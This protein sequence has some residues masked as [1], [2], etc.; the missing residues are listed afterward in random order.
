MKWTISERCIRQARQLVDE[1]RVIDVTPDTMHHRWLADVIADR[2]YHVIL[3]GTAQEKDICQCDYWKQHGYCEH[4]VAVE[5]QLNDKKIDRLMRENVNYAELFPQPRPSHTLVNRLQEFQK[6]QGIPTHTVEPL[7]LSAVVWMD[8]YH[9]CF[10]LELKIALNQK[11]ERLYVVRNVYDFLQAYSNCAVFEVNTRHHFQLNENVFKTDERQ[12]LSYLLKL[13]KEYCYL[14]GKEAARHRFERTVSLSCDELKGLMQSGLSNV[15]ENGILFEDKTVSLSFCEDKKPFH[16][17]LNGK[18][19]SLIIDWQDSQFWEKNHSIYLNEVMYEMNEQQW[20]LISLLHNMFPKEKTILEYEVSEWDDLCRD[21]LPL[22]E[23]I[24]HIQ[25]D[26]SLQKRL[27][28]KSLETHFY[29][30]TIPGQLLL[31]VDFQYGDVIFSS[32]PRKSTP[33]NNKLVRRDMMREQQILEILQQFGYRSVERN[34]L[35]K[36]PKSEALYRFFTEEI[37]QLKQYGTVQMDASL[38]NQFIND[39]APLIHVDESSEWLNIRFDISNIDPSEVEHILKTLKHHQSFYELKSGQMVDLEGEAFRQTSQVLEKLRLDMTHDGSIQLP[40]YQALQL[41]DTLASLDSVVYDDY[42]TTLADYLRHPSHFKVDVPS[43]LNASLRDYQFEGFQWMKMLSHYQLAGILADDMGLGKTL[44]TIT[45][46]L[47]EKE[48]GCLEHPALIVAPASLTYNWQSEIVRFAP[49]MSVQVVNGS[50]ENRIHLIEHSSKYDA[51]ITSYASFRQDAEYYQQQNFSVLILDEAQMVKNATTKTFMKLKQLPVTQ[52]FALSGTPIE[53]NLDELWSLFQMLMP[54]FFPSIRRFH[55]MDID[56]I[57]KMIQPF[58][59]RREKEAV[60]KDLPD[61]IETNLYSPLTDAQK[62]IYVAYLQKM[63]QEVNAMNH[64]DFRKHRISILAGLTRLRQICC[65]PALFMPDY[66]GQSGKEEQVK[67][68]VEQAKENHRRVLIFSQFTSMLDRLESEFQSIGVEA[69]YLNGTTNQ[70]TRLKMVNEFNEGQR[71]VFLISLKA[72][73]TG[74]NLTGAD[75]VILFD[76]WWNP[77]VEEQAASRAHRIGQK[78]VVEVWRLIAEGTIEEK[79]Y[80][81]QQEKKELF[82]K[83]MNADASQS[84]AQ[85]SEEDIRDILNYGSSDIF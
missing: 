56:V 51:L 60:L 80:Q 41:Q 81:L 43:N 71:D 13:Y 11:G 48:D 69:F 76:L 20:Q 18:P 27:V 85:L 70:E 3:D 65:T 37:P 19:L 68:L 5:I 50:K 55:Q 64:E 39:D 12:V 24:A 38:S 77:A 14:L 49:D 83:V 25:I 53:N 9:E 42:F 32:D 34:Y 52:R 84:L 4:T 40:K 72:G 62:N 44:Q 17:Q 57:S 1:K 10:Q 30:R 36:M 16:F 67:M 73:G 79:M 8:S 58:V 6:Y 7:K 15:L 74:L 63:K 33:S 2:I 22:L 29:F 28:D 47:S 31:R 26:S 46:L 78:K 21:V 23:Q 59:M 35:R 75:T 82:S 61:K 66:Q 54:G 45:Y